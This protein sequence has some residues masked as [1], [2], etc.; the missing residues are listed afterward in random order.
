MP[1]CKWLISLDQWGIACLIKRTLLEYEQWFFIFIFFN[2]NG[3]LNQ[4][5][6]SWPPEVTVMELFYQRIL[7]CLCL[8]LFLVKGKD[9]LN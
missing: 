1:K 7:D 3:F 9:D 5:H 8:P 6:L 4:L 2:E